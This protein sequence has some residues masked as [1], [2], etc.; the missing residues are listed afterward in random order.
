[1]VVAV[2]GEGLTDDITRWVEVVIDAVGY[3][4]VALLVALE[5]VFPPIPSEV[6]LPAAG[7]WAEQRSGPG[8]LVGMV[9]AATAGSVAGAWVLYA[10]AG[11]VG[12]DRVRAFVVRRGRWFGL[13]EGDLDRAERWF[14][15]RDEAAVLLCRCVPLVRSLVS[16]PAGFRRM[17]PW[18]FT[19][20]T[21]IGSAIWN[22]ALILVGYAAASHQEVVA[23]ILSIV[24]YGV[25]AVIVSA[26]GGFLWRRRARIR[27]AL[28]EPADG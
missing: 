15:R 18:R 20:Y 8:P 25:A 17:D 9:L 22:T 4:G 6:V 2:T 10:V 19:I 24:Q 12:P 11:S 21:A 5:N 26:V 28:S 13:K 23:D 27:Q 16:I 3:L 7:L 14:D 1:M